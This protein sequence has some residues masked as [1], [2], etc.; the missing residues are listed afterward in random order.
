MV[1]SELLLSRPAQQR[2]GTGLG[3]VFGVA[4][5]LLTAPPVHQRPGML[6]RSTARVSRAVQAVASVARAREPM[7]VPTDPQTLITADE[8]RNWM[9]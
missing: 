5:A 9:E 4:V 2:V 3:V 7:S 8:P 6:Q 1:Y